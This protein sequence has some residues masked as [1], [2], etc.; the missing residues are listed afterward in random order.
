MLKLMSAWDLRHIFLDI[1]QHYTTYIPMSTALIDFILANVIG[2]FLSYEK[3]K[4]VI[5]QY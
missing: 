2:V 1:V 5:F 4:E 3:L